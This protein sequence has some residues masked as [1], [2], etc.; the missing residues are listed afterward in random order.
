MTLTPYGPPL[1][2]RIFVWQLLFPTRDRVRVGV[3][4]GIVHFLFLVVSGDS[5]FL[6]DDI[7]VLE[8]LAYVLVVVK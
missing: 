3:V 7:G 2:L 4:R 8:G 1:T 5:Q 6:I